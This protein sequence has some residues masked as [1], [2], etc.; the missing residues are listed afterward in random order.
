MPDWCGH[1]NDGDDTAVTNPAR[2]FHHHDDGTSV[3]C[4]CHP[5]SAQAA[6]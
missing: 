6:A 3:R 2:R 1:C 5:G 4:H